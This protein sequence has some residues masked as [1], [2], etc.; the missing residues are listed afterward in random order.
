MNRYGVAFFDMV[1]VYRTEVY[2]KV[3]RL[4]GVNDDLNRARLRNH[5]FAFG[6]AGCISPD[7]YEMFRRNREGLEARDVEWVTLRRGLH[8]ER[9]EG[10]QRIGGLR[11]ETTQRGFWQQW[12]RVMRKTNDHTG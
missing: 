9:Q 2:T 11:D 8:S 4:P 3:V 12:K 7:D 10:N 5:Q 6:T 1:N